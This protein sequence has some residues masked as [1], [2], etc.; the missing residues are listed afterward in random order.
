[1]G[2]EQ[3]WWGIGL[4]ECLLGILVILGIGCLAYYYLASPP[5][6]PR[7]RKVNN[8]VRSEAVLQDFER[9][10]KEGKITRAQYE[11]LLKKYFP[12]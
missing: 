2:G 9:R 10:Y 7:S 1:M 8:H 11:D 5:A 6:R 4:Q 3:L 12:K